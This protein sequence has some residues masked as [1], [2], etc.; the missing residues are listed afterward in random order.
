MV[1]GRSMGG[2]L[3][4]ALGEGVVELGDTMGSSDA[5]LL[6]AQSLT[7]DNDITVQGDGSSTSTRILGGTNTA[8]A[9]AFSGNLTLG[10]DLVLTAEPGG[11]VRFQGMIENP[12]AHTLVKVG[13]G[14]VVF[15]GFQDHGPGAVFEILGGTVDL[16]TDASGTGLMADADLS[17]YVADATLNFGYNQHLDTLE[18]ADG[19]LV[20]LTGA[21]VVVVKHLV[22]NGIDL[23]GVTLTPEPATLGML[24]LGFVT[25]LVSRRR[26]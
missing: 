3:F 1:K 12:D 4:Y 25:M 2:L 24:A 16:N 11:E 5:A 23:G 6:V 7:V 18:I 14:T 13:G 19:G 22:M 17:I 21:N 15:D 26:R 8:G 20:R 10:K 9:A